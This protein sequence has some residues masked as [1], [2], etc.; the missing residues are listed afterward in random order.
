MEKVRAYEHFLQWLQTS[1]GQRFLQTEMQTIKR[2]SELWSGNYSLLLGAE[3]KDIKECGNFAH[4]NRVDFAQLNK[5]LPYDDG[6]FN[7][8]FLPHLLQYHPE[9]QL[10]LAEMTRLLQP[11]GHLLISGLNPFGPLLAVN[12]WLLPNDRLLREGHYLSARQIKNDCLEEFNVVHSQY[13]ARKL[14]L[15]NG[16]VITAQMREAAMRPVSVKQK[17]VK[18]P[19]LVSRIEV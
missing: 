13:F 3:F 2:L 19:A 6:S 16:Y 12:R 8:I 5:R 1:S 15:A 11:E 18:S 4:F 9:P 7:A 14:G 17:W 10:L